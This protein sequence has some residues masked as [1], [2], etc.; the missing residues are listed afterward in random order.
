MS[1]WIAL[2]VLSI[3]W[4]TDGRA[5]E[6]KFS[7]YYKNLLVSSQTV[8]PAGQRYT[9]DLNRLRLELKGKFSE[10]VALELQYDN[11][12]LLGN[13]LRTEQFAAQ[14]DQRADQLWNLDRDYGEGGSWYGRHRLY[15]GHVTLSSGDTDLRLGRQ[16]IAW[17]TGRFWSPVDLLNPINPIALEREERLGLDAVLAEHKLGPLSRISAVYA[18]RQDSGESSAALNWHSNAAGIDYS[19]IAGRFRSERVIGGDVATQLRGAGLRAELTHNER[20]AGP[21]Y[22]RA[23]LAMDYAFPNTL[24]LSGELYYNG[25][26]AAD[27]AAYDFASLFAGRVQNV[28]RRYFGGYAGYEITPLVKTVNYLVVNLADRSRFF[29]PAVIFSLQANLDLSLGVQ[30]FGGSPG[31]EYARLPDLYYAQVQWFF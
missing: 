2:A 4:S 23:V 5:Q 8:A 31:S 21:A 6:L 29:S 11:E 27:R 3:L 15:R 25:A 1:R 17:G 16:R 19:L 9:L 7:G 13:Y 30:F 24:T 12:V 18:P 26:G 20:D 22:H 10:S 14:K 28:G